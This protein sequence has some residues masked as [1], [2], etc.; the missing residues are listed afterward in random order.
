MRQLFR[1]QRLAGRVS[2]R[3]AIVEQR[4][5]SHCGSGSCRYTCYQ[6]VLN[7]LKLNDDFY[8]P[9][10]V[11]TTSIQHTQFPIGFAE[12]AAQI[13]AKVA[14]DFDLDGRIGSVQVVEVLNG[15]H[16]AFTGGV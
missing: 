3:L 2:T 5:S 10:D 12:F 8:P 11:N 9:P 7:S 13:E 15:E 16:V 1:E 4:P 6:T 14:Q